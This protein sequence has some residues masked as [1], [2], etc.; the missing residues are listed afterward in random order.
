MINHQSKSIQSI[1][2]QHEDYLNPVESQRSRIISRWS[3]VL[4]ISAVTITLGSCTKPPATTPVS[5]QLQVVTT[6][7][8]ITDF[9][10]AVAGDRAQVTQLLPTNVEPHDYQA[11]PGDAQKLAK[12]DVL[13]QNGLGIFDRIGQKYWQCQIKSNRF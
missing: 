11:K 1:A 3:S 9:T 4:F 6:F 5:K 12:A 13:V 2:T 7:I 10:K 8:P